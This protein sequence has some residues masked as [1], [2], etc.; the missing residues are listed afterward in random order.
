MSLYNFVYV[1]FCRRRRA[2]ICRTERPLPSSWSMLISVWF[3]GSHIQRTLKQRVLR[4]VALCGW[5]KPQGKRKIGYDW[6]IRVFDTQKYF[7]FRLSTLESVV[8]FRGSVGK[9]L[10]VLV[11]TTWNSSVVTFRA[12]DTLRHQMIELFCSCHCQKVLQCCLVCIGHH[13]WC[14][15]VLSVLI[16]CG[17]LPVE[18][19]YF[20]SISNM[21]SN[22]VIFLDIR[23]CR[24]LSSWKK[25]RSSWVY[26]FQ[27][28]GRFFKK[29]YRDGLKL[30]RRQEADSMTATCWHSKILCLSLR[31][32]MC[33]STRAG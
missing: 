29:L 20:P 16:T 1:Y 30:P 27:V 25:R 22:F 6:N 15:K 12:F 24:C 5:D 33:K 21:V 2:M 14:L 23:Q 10:R 3:R 26:K 28:R 13:L 18:F 17:S 4:L 31:S 9:R 7:I 11:W 32:K 19:P 8:F